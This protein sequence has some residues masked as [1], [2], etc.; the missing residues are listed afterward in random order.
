MEKKKR[1]IDLDHIV[2][3]IIMWLAIFALLLAMSIAVLSCSAN[4]N[5]VKGKHHVINDIA[6]ETSSVKFD[7][8]ELALKKQERT[9][10]KHSEV[11]EKIVD[12]LKVI[13][14]ELKDTISE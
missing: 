7:S 5:F 10:D 9:L 2:K 8:I 14:K 3:S 11:Q 4:I 13:Q 1:I 6:T 12:T